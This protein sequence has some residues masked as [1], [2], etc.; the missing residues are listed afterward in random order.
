MTAEVAEAYE[1]LRSEVPW[2]RQS[3]RGHCAIAAVLLAKLNA[4]TATVP[5]MNLL[6]LCLGQMGATPTTAS[7][8][9]MP[10][11]ED[12]HDDLLD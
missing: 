7:K 6:R 2:L 5:E 10:F 4:G 12:E 8:V 3:H 11:D 9:S 1:Q